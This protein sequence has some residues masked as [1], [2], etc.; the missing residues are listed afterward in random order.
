MGYGWDNLVFN[1]Y[2]SNWDKLDDLHDT[3]TPTS[4]I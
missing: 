1:D 2:P 4:T 3:T